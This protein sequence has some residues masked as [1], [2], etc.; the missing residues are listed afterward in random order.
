MWNLV[1]VIHVLVNVK[2]PLTRVYHL[3]LLE[4]VHHHL[5]V[6]HCMRLLVCELATK[7]E[8][9]LTELIDQRC[10]RKAVV[11][12]LL[13]LGQLCQSFDGLL[14][15][16]FIVIG[17]SEILDELRDGQ[18]FKRF[19]LILGLLQSSFFAP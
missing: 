14:K 2:A 7:Q 11:H 16:C 1:Q 4:D 13:D 18:D 9:G 5:C 3:D 17:N 15:E 6:H 19:G 12:I 8:P 10:E